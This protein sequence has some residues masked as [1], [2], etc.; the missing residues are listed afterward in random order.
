MIK[1]LCCGKKNM[2]NFRMFGF[3]FNSQKVLQPL[4][5]TYVS[6]LLLNPT[7]CKAQ[8]TCVLWT[9]QRKVTVKCQMYLAQKLVITG[10]ASGVQSLVYW[11]AMPEAIWPTAVLNSQSQLT[12]NTPGLCMPKIL[13]SWRTGVSGL[14]CDD[15]LSGVLLSLFL[16]TFSIMYKIKLKSLNKISSLKSKA[17]T[18]HTT[19]FSKSLKN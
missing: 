12:G 9:C 18:S 2:R 3:W 17:P 8:K 19:K 13:M 10:P 5:Q 7:R 4:E 6:P 14:C 11:T 15:S 16:H 1:K